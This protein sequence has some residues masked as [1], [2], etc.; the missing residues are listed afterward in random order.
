MENIKFI[1]TITVNGE[2]KEI[3]KEEAAQLILK[4]IEATLTG[5]NYEKGN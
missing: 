5:V 3:P 2:K 1:T 4:N